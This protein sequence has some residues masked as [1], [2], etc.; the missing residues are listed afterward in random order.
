MKNTAGFTIVE[1]LLVI[2]IMIALIATGIGV[3]DSFKRDTEARTLQTT[4]DTLF[5]S[6]ASYYYA[7][8]K[9]QYNAETG[10]V[11]TNKA[12]L[13][14][15]NNPSSPFPVLNNATNLLLSGGF[16]SSQ[17]WPP[18]ASTFVDSTA[19]AK[20]FVAQFNQ[21]PAATR[22]PTALYNNWN[23]SPPFTVSVSKAN[24]GNIIVW[25]AQVAVKLASTLV[26]K[27]TVFQKRLAANCTSTSNGTTV[28][29]CSANTPGPYLVWERLPTYANSRAQSKSWLLAPI[30]KMFNQNNTNNDLY[31][32]GS[33]NNTYWATAP[34]TTAGSNNNYLCGG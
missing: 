12:S 13:D 15:I 22:A 19:D 7:N 17:E 14:P 2:V 29:P 28:N 24:M 21:M 30:F 32:A 25:R 31:G 33:G 4:V 18:V 27:A 6:M 23:A 20:G 8:C 3:Y 16:I 10:A 11:A 34:S 1:T 5:L 9:Q 26:P